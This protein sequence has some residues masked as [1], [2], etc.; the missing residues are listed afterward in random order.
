MHARQTYIPSPY[1]FLFCARILVRCTGLVWTYSGPT[2]G[3]SFSYICLIPLGNWSCGSTPDQP[4]YPHFSIWTHDLWQD[5]SYFAISL[6]PHAN[7]TN[8]WKAAS[9]GFSL[10]MSKAVI[11]QFGCSILTWDGI[12]WQ[13]A[14]LSCW[15]E[16]LPMSKTVH[17]YFYM[18]SFHTACQPPHTFSRLVLPLFFIV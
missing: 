13:P 9:L 10:H 12:A 16:A 6:I 7:P 3:L 2:L 18:D 4:C 8:V 14:G 11:L 17:R 5:V 1:T 15:V